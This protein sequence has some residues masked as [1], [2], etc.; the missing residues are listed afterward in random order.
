V[1]GFTNVGIS[2]QTLVSGGTGSPTWVAPGSLANV[3]AGGV[4]ET[5]IQG[6]I[7]ELDT[8]KVAKSGDT[9]TG[10]LSF[11][12]NSRRIKGDFSNATIANRL[13]FQT[14][15]VNGNTGVSFLPN[16]TGAQTNLLLHNTS[17]TTDYGYLTA[18]CSA[19]EASFRQ[20]YTGVGSFLPMTF[21]AGGA[22]RMRIATDG[23]IT[24]PGTLAMGSAFGF[25]NRI[26]NGNFGINQR[27]YVSAAAVGTNLYGHDRWKMAASA[28]TYTFATSLNVTTITIPAGKVL[29]QVI[30]GLNLQSGTHTL[31]WVGTAQGKI[32]A[33][34]YGASG[35]TGVAV[36]GTNLTIEFGPGT[37][38]KVQ[39]EEGSIATP[40]ENRH[41]GQELSLCQRY[42]EYMT[43]IVLGGYG[44]AAQAMTLPP[45]VFKVEK[46][47]TP[48]VTPLNTAYVNASNLSQQGVTTT[49][50]NSY[51]VA[52]TSINAV[53][54]TD[55]SIS[56]E[57]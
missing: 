30:E 26:I 47:A 46:R 48:T 21:H 56:S 35:I 38:S 28:D 51:H 2:G 9:M 33:G 3:P 32:G 14:S 49:C 40:F 23:N 24:M 22:E 54:T 4:T 13:M 20:S 12:G 6:A 34:A 8:K 19:G 11:S 43:S 44:L 41:Y 52:T 27:G 5:A 16:G 25:R 10:D 55:L 36:G 15:T 17:N 39:L 7:N 50:W 57:L 18:F 1:T 45:V 37:V 42:Y 29:R 31:S 53:T